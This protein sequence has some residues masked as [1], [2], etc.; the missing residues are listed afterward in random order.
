MDKEIDQLGQR[1]PSDMNFAPKIDAVM[2]KWYAC[3]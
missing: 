2:L 1:Y 3:W